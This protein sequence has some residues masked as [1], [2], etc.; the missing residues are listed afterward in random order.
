MGLVLCPGVQVLVRYCVQMYKCGSCKV[1]RCVWVWY[2]SRCVIVGL[3][4]CPGVQVLVWQ[5]V[6][7]RRC[8]SGTVSGCT[9][10]R[11]LYTQAY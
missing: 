7:V 3:V 11:F 9:G 6:Q 8:G 10:V 1:S 2:V 5:C 4:L